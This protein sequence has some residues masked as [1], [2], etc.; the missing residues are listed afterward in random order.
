MRGAGGVR[1]LR[2]LLCLVV[3]TVTACGGGDDAVA[4]DL[5]ID[6]L[7]VEC[8]AGDMSA[9][10][11]LFLSAPARSVH[12]DFGETCGGRNS[13]GGWCVNLHEMEVDLDEL[14]DLCTGGNAF[15]CDLLFLYAP[16][17]S[18]DRAT[19]SSCGGRGRSAPSCVLDYWRP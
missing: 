10:D 18:P 11:V 4:T 1:R 8:E 15:A 5:I 2:T 9:C 16:I 19:G 7:R 3:L 17:D 13:P 6:A 12:A 14:R